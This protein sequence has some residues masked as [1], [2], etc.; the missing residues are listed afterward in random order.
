MNL[1]YDTTH[2]IPDK[3]GFIKIKNFCS[4]KDGIK[5]NRRQA[6]DWEKIFAKDTS[7]K[8]TLSEKHKEL[9]KFNNKT[10][11]RGVPCWSRVGTPG[12]HCC[13]LKKGLILGWVT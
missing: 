12:F 7:D 8:G 4:A 10:N 9:L 11:N 1:I 3:L 2:E 6:I 5:N 13:G